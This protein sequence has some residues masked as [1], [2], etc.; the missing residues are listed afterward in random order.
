ME[1]SSSTGLWVV[2][3]I[4]DSSLVA[5]ERGCIVSEVAV[6]W[7]WFSSHALSTALPRARTMRPLTY[8]TEAA[9]LAALRTDLAGLFATDL[10]DLHV[11]ELTPEEVAEIMSC[12]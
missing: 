10:G 9:A 2:E 7:F 8:D 5:V 4:S 6:G 1:R 11:R 3:D 12:G